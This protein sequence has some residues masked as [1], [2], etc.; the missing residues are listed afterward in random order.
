MSQSIIKL[1]TADKFNQII[2]DNAAV[3]VDFYADWCGPCRRLT[4][5]IEEKIK[6]SNFIL[7]KVDVDKFGELAS[8]YNVSG[9]PH[10]ILF[11]DGKKADELV[12]ADFKALDKMIA[13]L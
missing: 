1:D 2:K 12:G 11:K 10:V 13:G 5:Y 8:E 9:I 3:L 7:L 4:P 6:G